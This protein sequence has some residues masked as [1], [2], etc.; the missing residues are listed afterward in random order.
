M[1]R[2]ADRQTDRQTG[3]VVRCV[4]LQHFY[5]ISGVPGPT[6]IELTKSPLLIV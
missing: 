3:K 5:E 6:F 4:I 1:E 2:Q